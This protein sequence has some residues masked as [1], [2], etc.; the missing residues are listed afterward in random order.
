M[1]GGDHQIEV[2]TMSTLSVVSHVILITLLLPI[3]IIWR[4]INGI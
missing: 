2:K 1:Y 4:K 3:V